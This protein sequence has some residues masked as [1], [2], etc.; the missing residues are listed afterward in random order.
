MICGTLIFE[1]T[2]LQFKLH[3]EDQT[4][5]Y[6]VADN[7]EGKQETKTV[8]AG[9]FFLAGAIL[10]AGDTIASSEQYEKA[11]SIQPDNKEL[12]FIP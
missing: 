2:L 4:V 5:T 11:E 7:L 10:F 3:S 8:E 1:D 12:R 9:K 6:T